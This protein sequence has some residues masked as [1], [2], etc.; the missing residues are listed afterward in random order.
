MNLKKRWPQLSTVL[1]WLIDNN[2][3]EAVEVLHAIIQKRTRELQ[4]KDPEVDLTDALKSI[5]KTSIR[6]GVNFD[7]LLES[8]KRAQMTLKESREQDKEDGDFDVW[9]EGVIQ[10]VHE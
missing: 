1:K 7:R 9:I 8:R 3:E 4:R 2:N 5:I 10:K 6:E